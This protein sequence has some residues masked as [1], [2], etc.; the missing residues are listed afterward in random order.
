MSQ[1]TPNTANTNPIPIPSPNPNS[2]SS[3]VP[4]MQIKELT[5]TPPAEP[6]YFDY[7]SLVLNHGMTM[8]PPAFPGIST[9][10]LRMP[11]SATINIKPTGMIRDFS[12]DMFPESLDPTLFSELDQLGLSLSPVVEGHGDMDVT[13]GDYD[14]EHQDLIF[15]LMNPHAANEGNPGFAV[16][17]RAGT[18][19]NRGNYSSGSSSDGLVLGDYGSQHC[20]GRALEILAK[21]HNTPVNCTLSASIPPSGSAQDGSSS[22]TPSVPTP[23]GTLPT[24]TSVPTPLTA[25]AHLAANTQPASSTTTRSIDQVL[26]TNKETVKAVHRI[27]D[28][29]CSLNLQT[30]LMLT[31]IVSK[32]LCWYGAVGRAHSEN[33]EGFARPNSPELEPTA[34]RGSS[35]MSM[36]LNLSPT[37]TS[38]RTSTPTPTPIGGITSPMESVSLSEPS[39]FVNKYTPNNIKA[40]DASR[41]SA[42]VVLG[43]LHLVLRLVKKL[44]ARFR[45]IEGN[46]NVDG[47]MSST[48]AEDPGRKSRTGNS[49]GAKSAGMPVLVEMERFL[50]DQLKVLAR[51]TTNMLRSS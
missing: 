32:V 3:Q 49:E 12:G 7:S 45:R 36:S 28:C 34:G 24:P 51:E 4:P 47:H 19:T 43:E 20:I 18:S 50:L 23:N 27:L 14:N 5:P 26:A 16:G 22:T 40:R 21:L 35:N 25:T 15:S 11:E 8:N 17:N 31:T 42:Q 39:T 38:T 33:Q 30:A 2:N 37:P 46:G 41:I 6:G 44:V 1:T 29:P 9:Q 48:A 13:M 10:M